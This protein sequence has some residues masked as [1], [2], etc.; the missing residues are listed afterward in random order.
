MCLPHCKRDAVSVRKGLPQWMWQVL[1]YRV[2]VGEKV[3][4]PLWWKK[5][6]VLNLPIRAQVTLPTQVHTTSIPA[7][8][9][10]YKAMWML[11]KRVMAS[12]FKRPNLHVRRRKWHQLL[13]LT[14]SFR[15]VTQLQ[16]SSGTVHP[17]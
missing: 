10:M 2:R 14:I 17:N 11:R 13:P 12:L 9:R 15:P 3:I 7:D 16:A 4:A 8:V 1:P 5:G 6:D